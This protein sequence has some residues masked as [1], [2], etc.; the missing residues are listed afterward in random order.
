MPNYEMW[1]VILLIQLLGFRILLKSIEFLFYFLTKVVVVDRLLNHIWPGA[2]PIK[3]FFLA[4]EEFFRFLLIRLECLV[5]MIK[6]VF[7]IKWLTAKF[8]KRRKHSFIG[9]VP[10]KLW[11]EQK[12]EKYRFYLFKSNF[13]HFLHYNLY[14]TKTDRN[15]IEKSGLRKTG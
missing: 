5:R 13:V 8:G 3:L 6:N 9:S 4:S 7:S 15:K 12:T 1:E 10:V 2:D 14:S 11:N